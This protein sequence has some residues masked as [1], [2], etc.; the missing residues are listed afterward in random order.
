M[1]KLSFKLFKINFKVT[2]FKDESLSYIAP[3]WE[4]MGELYLNLGVQILKNN[5]KFD[6]LVTLAKGGWTWSRTMADILDIKDIYSFKL[7]LYDDF[8]PGKILDKPR[9]EQPLTVPLDKKS[10]LF[11]DDVNDTGQSLIW[12]IK[13]L[14]FFNLKS[15]KTATLFHK[16]HS[17]F[18]PD[19]YGYETSAW[20]I[21]PH[22]R[23]E[24]IVGLSKKWSKKGIKTDEIKDRLKKIGLPKK[25][26]DLFLSL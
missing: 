9:L 19:F 17:K 7:T 14:D 24:G 26:I 16:P 10:I 13:Y 11:F 4:E 21:F 3:T 2:K 12:S 8:V 1:N 18:I 23:R 15:I 6:C 20:I 5:I 22:E 25:E